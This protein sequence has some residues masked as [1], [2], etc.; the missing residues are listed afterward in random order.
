MLKRSN[1]GIHP[2]SRKRC[3][4]EDQARRRRGGE[5]CG[6][7]DLHEQARDRLTPCGGTATGSVAK[8]SRGRRDELSHARKKLGCLRF[9][10]GWGV[11]TVRSLILHL[12]VF[13]GL[14]ELGNVCGSG[15]VTQLSSGRRW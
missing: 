14:A 2:G 10:G 6:L 13:T 7:S 1:H 12:C 5:R 15:A 9:R 11:E 8:L 4:V 3:E